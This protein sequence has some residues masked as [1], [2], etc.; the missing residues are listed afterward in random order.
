MD[1]YAQWTLDSCGDS[2]QVVAFENK[3][4]IRAVLFLSQKGCLDSGNGLGFPSV[5]FVKNMSFDCANPG[6]LSDFDFMKSNASV[7]R[8]CVENATPWKQFIHMHSAHGNGTFLHPSAK[9]CSRVH[10]Q[11][12]GTRIVPYKPTYGPHDLEATF[13]G[14]L[15]EAKLKESFIP[16][17]EISVKPGGA[18]VVHGFPFKDTGLTFITDELILPMTPHRNL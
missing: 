18:V 11:G 3:K 9:R 17:G 10:Q 13:Q 7:F 16:R 1:S 5:S 4:D 6:L 8:G 12:F 15:D 2:N 14:A